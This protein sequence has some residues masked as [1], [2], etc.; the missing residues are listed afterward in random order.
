VTDI[1]TDPEDPGYNSFVSLEEAD[2]YFSTTYWA[3]GEITWDMQT[4]EDQERLLI[5]A[6][7]AVSALPWNGIPV[8]PN[9]TL[10]FPRNFTYYG[11]IQGISVNPPWLK[12]LTLE[13]AK[14]LFQDRAAVIAQGELR[15]I[16]KMDV[17]TLSITYQDSAGVS[18]DFISNLPASILA[19]LAKLN[20]YFITLKQSKVQSMS[21]VF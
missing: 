10:A 9:Q 17:D 14:W 12:P 18:G 1:I 3:P 20:P 16:K 19:L 21:M 4:P 15:G 8:D 2:A 5:S 13:Y 7:R 11:F 6:S